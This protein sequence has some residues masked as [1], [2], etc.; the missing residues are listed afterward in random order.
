MYYEMFSVYL[1]EVRREGAFLDDP[2]GLTFAGLRA[3]E[4]ILNGI[5]SKERVK[6]YDKEST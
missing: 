1:E 2:V 4:S 6:D 5:E 3:L